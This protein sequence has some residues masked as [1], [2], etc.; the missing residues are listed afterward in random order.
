M[1]SCSFFLE[2]FCG[3]AGV[4]TQFRQ[5]GGQPLGNDH[6]LQRSRLKSAAVKLDITQDWVQ[7]LILKEIAPGRV[8]A[9]HLGPPCGTASKARSIPVRK[10]LRRAGA[11]NPKPLRSS[12]NPQGFPWLKGVS[13]QRCQL[14]PRVHSQSCPSLRG[15]QCAFYNRKSCKFI[16]VGDSVFS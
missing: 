4:C 12:K 13:L 15:T 9:V 6:N 16:R 3:T 7:D 2:L 5:M 14:A 10:K 11:P 1:Q 8:D